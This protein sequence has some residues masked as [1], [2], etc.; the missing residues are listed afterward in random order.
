MYHLIITQLKTEENLVLRQKWNT[1]NDRQ[2]VTVAFVQS[3]GSH[4]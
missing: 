2:K 3:K 1:Y 4:L